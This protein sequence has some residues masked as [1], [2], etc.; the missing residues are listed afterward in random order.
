M[1]FQRCS[2]FQA[3]DPFHSV[4][5]RTP[6]H[7]GNTSHKLDKYFQ[8]ENFMKKIQNL[9]CRKILLLKYNS[10]PKQVIFPLRK[11]SKFLVRSK[12]ILMIR[13]PENVAG[14]CQLTYRLNVLEMTNSKTPPTIGKKKVH[15]LKL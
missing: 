3:Y 12:D 11:S 7:L 1:S 2:E 5:S 8:G 14:T 15:L 9:K 10:N 6:M 13:N 4:K